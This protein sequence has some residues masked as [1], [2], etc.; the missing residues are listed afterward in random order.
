MKP[1][2]KSGFTLIELLVVIAIIAILAAILFPVFAKAREKAR[3]TT[4]LSNMKQIALSMTMYAQDSDEIFPPG[5]YYGPNVPVAQ[6]WD[7]YIAPYAV[8]SGARYYGD[9]VSNAYLECPSDTTP[10]SGTS[11][12]K[13]SYAVVSWYRPDEAWKQ[14]V[15]LPSGDAI[16]SGRAQSEFPAP[17][18]TFLLVEMPTPGNRIAN[19][20]DVAARGPNGNNTSGYGQTGGLNSMVGSITIKPSHSDGWNYA[21]ADG[22]A[23]WMRPETTISTPGVTYPKV[24]SMGYNCTNSMT[25]PCGMWTVADD[26]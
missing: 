14:E 12:N 9:K 3:Q 4:C 13:R 8:K 18:S 15:T 7:D 22:H 10:R 23:K 21:F 16:M 6:A 20:T 24:N 5:R 25:N 1:Q 26:D 2:S 17:A 11:V 19:N